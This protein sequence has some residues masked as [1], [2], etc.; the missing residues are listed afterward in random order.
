MLD[1]I[2]WV[3]KGELQLVPGHG[4]DAAKTMGYGLQFSREM[5]AVGR[6]SYVVDKVLRRHDAETR[7]EEQV[8]PIDGFEVRLSTLAMIAEHLQHRVA[9]VALTGKCL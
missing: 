4:E 8:G 2:A 1:D 7:I 5:S 6:E 3:V 9:Q